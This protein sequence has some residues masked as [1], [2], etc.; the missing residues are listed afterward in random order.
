VTYAPIF[1][2]ALIP[3]FAFQEVTDVVGGDA[4]WKLLFASGRKA[5]RLVQK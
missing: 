3:F 2:V 1:F 4:L 5:F